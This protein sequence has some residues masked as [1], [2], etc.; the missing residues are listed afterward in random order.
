MYINAPPIEFAEGRDPISLSVRSMIANLGD[1]V[2]ARARASAPTSVMPFDA[3]LTSVSDDDA[4][5]QP[6]NRMAPRS[7]SVV[8]LR[9]RLMIEDTGCAKRVARASIPADSILGLLASERRTK[10]G[11]SC[12]AAASNAHPAAVISELLRSRSRNARFCRIE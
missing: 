1:T 4:A 6:H 8:L 2:I 11:C 5:K 12:N 3:R 7:C 10:L 9:S